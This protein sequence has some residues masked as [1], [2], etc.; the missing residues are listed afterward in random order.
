MAAPVEAQTNPS[1]QV[2]GIIKNR[3]ITELIGSTAE[4][5]E[6]QTALNAGF[7]GCHKEAMRVS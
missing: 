5:V 7:V 3:L 6:A 1:S 2:L 4:P